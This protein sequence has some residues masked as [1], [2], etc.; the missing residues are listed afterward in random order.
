MFSFKDLIIFELSKNHA[1]DVSHGL[2]TIDAF[3]K[4]A[5]EEGLRGAVKLQ[6][7]DLHTYIHPGQKEAGDPRVKRYFSSHLSEED[8]GILVE[9]IRAHGLLTVSTPFDEAS[10][11]T[12][13]RLNVEVIKIASASAKDVPL[14]K[15]AV[16]SKK[17]I[18][19]STGGL[20]LEDIDSLYAFFK[21]EGATFALL[22]CVGMYPTPL[23]DMQL[24]RIS[25]MKARYPDVEIG[26]STHEDPENYGVVQMAYAKGARLF[27]KHIILVDEKFKDDAAFMK[28]L[29]YT[30]QPDQIKKWIHSYKD[31]IIMNGVEEEG[32][33]VPKEKEL[34]SL[35]SMM[36]GVYAA[37]DI[38]KG[39]SV[40][41]DQVYFA[42]PLE[43]GCLNSG[44]F[45][46]G[47]IADRDYKK[48]E[49]LKG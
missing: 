37:T 20:T 35:Q 12:I 42:V 14:L 15:R 31:A 40:A 10:V 43:S 29:G 39:D 25:L 47:M 8:F 26:F 1:G 34:Q 7:R 36:R 5:K 27:E 6:F 13:D 49:A 16:A 19:C 3:A 33:Y 48:D 17:P 22:H 45:V 23:E 18:V 41:V 38:K 21:K 32:S 11:D 9:A 46:G 2:K 4:L 28:V 30:A 24:N 44:T